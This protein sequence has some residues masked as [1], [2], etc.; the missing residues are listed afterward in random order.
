MTGGITDTPATVPIADGKDV[1]I[2]PGMPYPAPYR[3][4]KYSV[5][6]SRRHG[7]VLQWKYNDLVV[8]VE[9]PDGLLDRLESLGK[10]RGSGKGSVRITA[11]RDVLTK[12]HSSNYP[13]I[14]QAPVDSGWI[15]VYVGHLTG[16]FGFDIELDPDP[17]DTELWVWSGFSFNHGESWGVAHDDRLVWKWQD[18]RFYSAFDHTDLVETYQQYRG[19]AGRL[20]INEFGHVFI[21]ID[22][23]SVPPSEE[24]TVERAF[25]EWKATV[26]R[27]GNTA[28]Q[29][30]VNRRLKVTGDGD[31]T[32]GLLPMYVGHLSD[33]DEGTVP[34]PVV[35]DPDYYVAAAREEDGGF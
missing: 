28:A 12:I 33:F 1:S 10:S 16:E 32:E 30:L 21:N 13:H 14:A 11:G 15:P 17:P 22:R 8:H 34:K 6:D 4:S 29:R 31:P 3:G 26:E 7:T 35:T 18:Y 20:Y 2:E 24:A 27:E 5:I 23:E 19:L 9:P 25:A